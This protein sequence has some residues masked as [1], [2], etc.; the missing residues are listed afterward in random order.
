[1][2]KTRKRRFDRAM[3][4]IPKWILFYEAAEKKKRKKKKKGYH[5]RETFQYPWRC[6]RFGDH[7]EN[8]GNEVTECASVNGFGGG[9]A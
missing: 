4:S 3:E 9:S 5:K 2:L 8:H 7:G 1:M 6:R